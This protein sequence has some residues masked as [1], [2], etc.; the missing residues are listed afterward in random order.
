MSD[1]KDEPD[2]IDLAIRAERARC[3]SIVE[4]WLQTFGAKNPQLIS[5]QTWA[6]DALKDIADLIRSGKQPL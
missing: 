1:A 6:T 5:A 2:M 3:I 4:T